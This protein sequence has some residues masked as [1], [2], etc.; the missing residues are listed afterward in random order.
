MLNSIFFLFAALRF[1]FETFTITILKKKPT[2]EDFFP[3]SCNKLV[4]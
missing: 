3:K 4:V 1:A 2:C